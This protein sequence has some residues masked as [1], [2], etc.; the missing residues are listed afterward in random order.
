[1]TGLP[2]EVKPDTGCLCG[3]LQARIGEEW[4]RLQSAPDA[5]RRCQVEMVADLLRA[6]DPWC[7]ANGFHTEE[8]GAGEWSPACE[9]AAGI[10][11]RYLVHETH[12]VVPP[13]RYRLW[14]ATDDD[15]RCLPLADVVSDGGVVRVES[16]RRAATPPRRGGAPASHPMLALIEARR[17]NEPNTGPRSGRTDGRGGRGMR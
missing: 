14:S 8:M 13:G 2:E 11:P 9:H 7:E 5:A 6:L 16:N 3:E 1:M 15:P 10:P 4:G 17:R 12:R